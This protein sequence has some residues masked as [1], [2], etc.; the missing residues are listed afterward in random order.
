MSSHD[1]FFYICNNQFKITRDRSIKT[2]LEFD[3]LKTH[4][5]A[6]KPLYIQELNVNLNPPPYLHLFRTADHADWMR[7]EEDL[8]AMADPK[9]ERN[10]GTRGFKRSRSCQNHSRR[11]AG[12]RAR[13]EKKF[14]RFVSTRYRV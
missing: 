6:I 11:R 10:V 12:A 5:T 7:E 2:S 9:N 8:Q 4:E 13:N 1:F 3:L 14:T